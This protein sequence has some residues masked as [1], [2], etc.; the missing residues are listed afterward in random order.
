M[1]K[2][3][4]QYPKKDQF[5]LLFCTD[6][7]S[8]GVINVSK[9]VYYLKSKIKAHRD[10][11][12]YSG[13]DNTGYYSIE[14]PNKD[15]VF[16][17]TF[18][19]GERGNSHVSYHVEA[20]KP[21]INYKKAY[22]Y[23]WKDCIIVEERKDSFAVAEYDVI[24]NDTGNVITDLKLLKSLTDFIFHKP[25]SVMVTRKAQVSMATYFPHTKEEFIILPGCG[26]KLYN[27]CGE[28]IMDFIKSYLDSNEC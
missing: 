15:I 1:Y 11:M 26:E 16:T 23:D 3:D 9:N 22:L 19:K 5:T 18:Q 6:G 8:W 10:E 4:I 2:Y 13:H 12:I 27:K 28:M 25:V 20:P 7:K 17:Q 21:K 14:A 24:C